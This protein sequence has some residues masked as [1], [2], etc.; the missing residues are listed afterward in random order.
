VAI[1]HQYSKSSE[2]EAD[3]QAHLQ[4]N[5]GKTMRYYSLLRPFS[6]LR[7]A[8]LFAERGFAKYKDVFSS[9]NRAYT[10]D[11]HEL[12]WCGECPKCA[13]VF[14][15]LAPF[16]ERAEL[17]SLWHGKNLLLDPELEDTYRGLLGIKGDK[18]LECVGEVKECR[19]AMQMAQKTYPELAKYTFELPEDYDY[20]NLGPNLIP[21]DIN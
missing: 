17:E 5:F 15:A 13:F 1:N 12:F 6:E 8:Q 3:Y 7:I 4:R 16:V 10:H 21:D 20:R 9:C 11:S 14:L 18:P 2:F 19:A